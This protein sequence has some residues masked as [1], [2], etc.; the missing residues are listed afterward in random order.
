MAII[1][2]SWITS[3]ILISRFYCRYNFSKRQL[4]LN[5]ISEYLK[6]RVLIEGTT[7]EKKYEGDIAD[8]KM[9]E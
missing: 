4:E 2:F 8:I 1:M 3:T 6:Q 7:L 5:K 9:E